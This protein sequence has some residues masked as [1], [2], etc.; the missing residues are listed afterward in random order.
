M[1][2]QRFQLLKR[3]I[4]NPGRSSAANITGTQ[5]RTNQSHT[6]TDTQT[7]RQTDGQTQC[8]LTSE[9]VPQLG[10]TKKGGTL[11][12]ILKKGVHIVAYGEVNCR[13]L[14][15]LNINV[16]PKLNSN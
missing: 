14:A 5:T 13:P 1:F 7:D 11:H 4:F 15:S 9:L 10:V 6:H 2:T 8:L 3:V 12:K 16:V